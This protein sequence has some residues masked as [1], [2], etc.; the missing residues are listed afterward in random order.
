LDNE[1]E[2]HGL[3][4]FLQRI[5][6]SLLELF[7]LVGHS[8]PN[9]SFSVFEQ[10]VNEASQ[11]VGGGGHRFGCAQA[12]FH[13]PVKSAQSAPA[14][15]QRHRRYPQG[16]GD[17]IDDSACVVPNTLP[18]LIRMPLSSPPG[19]HTPIPPPSATD[20]HT[21]A[22]FMGCSTSTSIWRTAGC[23]KSKL[24]RP[25]RKSIPCSNHTL[26]QTKRNR[27]FAGERTNQHTESKCRYS[28]ATN[29]YHAVYDGI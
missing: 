2:S 7:L 3:C 6:L 22:Y 24:S 1:L 15:L 25:A 9:V 29:C 18:P 27:R 11:F 12:G 20:T 10:S 13:A 4:G 17:T 21:L 5:E 19:T 16:I 14:S 23:C 28:N 26:K 8:L